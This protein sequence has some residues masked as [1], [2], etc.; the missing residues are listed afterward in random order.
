MNNRFSEFDLSNFSDP[1]VV[2]GK[3]IDV[4]RLY[5]SKECRDKA[6]KFRKDVRKSFARV[7]PLGFT[8]EFLLGNQPVMRLPVYLYRFF[9]RGFNSFQLSFSALIGRNV[10]YV[11]DMWNTFKSEI[12]DHAYA[13]IVNEN[14]LKTEDCYEFRKR[15]EQ[16]CDL[17]LVA[18]DTNTTCTKCGSKYLSAGLSFY[19]YCPECNDCNYGK[20]PF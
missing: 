1:C 3:A 20:I 6:A 2:C 5:C 19:A 16:W 7:S 8:V 10:A 13:F 15:F 9:P 11:G 17:G 12:G 18:E 4:K 14:Q